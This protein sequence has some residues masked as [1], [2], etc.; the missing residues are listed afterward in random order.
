MRK[1]LLVILFFYS[2]HAMSQTF[3]DWAKL[4]NWDGVTP[5]RQYLRYSP[6]FMGPNALP[7]PEIGNGTVDSINHISVSGVFHF[8][9]GD[10]TQNIKLRGNYCLVKDFISADITWI[11]IEWFRQSAGIKN[12]RHVYYHG[13]YDQKAAG[14]IYLNVNVQLLSRWRK[15]IHL[16]FRT[17]FRYPTSSSVGAARYTD[18]PGYHF[19]LSG[20]IPLSNKFKFTTMTGFYVWQLNKKGQN[21]AILFGGGFEYNHKGWRWQTNCRGYSGYLN[22][23]DRPVIVGSQLEKKSKNISFL[24]GL[25]QGLHDYKYTSIELGTKY[26]FA[27]RK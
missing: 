25:H 8:S 21:D 10:H 9:K 26:S 11:P 12:E 15:Y 1:G 7:V 19:D 16:V 6:G 4:V 27:K 13:Y 17:G 20:G 24:F 18:A 23:G 22:N 5:W 3:N 14:D 2:T